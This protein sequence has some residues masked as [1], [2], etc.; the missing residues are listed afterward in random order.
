MRPARLLVLALALP[1]GLLASSV[2]LPNTFSNGSL[3]DA[4][5][6]NANFTAIA[7]A[8]NDTDARLTKFETTGAPSLNV[9]G[10]GTIGGSLTVAGGSNLVSYQL[11]HMALTH[12]VVTAQCGTGTA[13]FVSGGDQLKNRTGNQLCASNGRTL[14]TCTGVRYWYGTVDN[15]WGRYAAADKGCATGLSNDAIWPFA[16]V[17]GNSTLAGEWILSSLVVCCQ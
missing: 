10:N 4:A 11:V 15:S 14:R 16:T 13:I 6:I 5:A 3:A 12:P 1:A 2:V 7:T 8:A 9:S 17:G